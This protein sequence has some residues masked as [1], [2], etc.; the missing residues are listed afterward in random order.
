MFDINDLNSPVSFCGGGGGGGGGD[1][2]DSYGVCTADDRNG[3]G[4]A[5]RSTVGV[6]SMSSMG[7]NGLGMS[8]TCVST[9]DSV[10]GNVSV[11]CATSDA[12]DI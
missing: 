7:E 9:H 5:D 2:G 6:R 11:A 8:T 12:F 10:T 4:V 3:D 1:G